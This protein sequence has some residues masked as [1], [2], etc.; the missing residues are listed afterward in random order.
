M[1]HRASARE[2]ESR[3]REEAAALKH[4]CVTVLRG[5]RLLVLLLL[6]F[7][8]AYAHYAFEVGRALF[9][10]FF[11]LFHGFEAPDNGVS[12][13]RENTRRCSG[14]FSCRCYRAD[15]CF[16]LQDDLRGSLGEE[17]L[18]YGALDEESVLDEDGDL[19]VRHDE[20][21]EELLA[22]APKPRVTQK[23]TLAPPKTKSPARSKKTGGKALAGDD[24]VAEISV[25]D[26]PGRV[27]LQ[28]LSTQDWHSA[29]EN[30]GSVGGAAVL[31]SYWNVDEGHYP[32]GHTLRFTSG[33]AY[34]A[35]PPLVSV[36][37][38]T[39]AVYTER[40]LKITADTFG[41]HNFDK[42]FEHVAEMAKV[43]AT[44]DRKVPGKPFRVVI[45]N[46][47]GRER[48]LPETREFIIV[49]GGGVKIGIVGII[50]PEAYKD[51]QPK[52]WGS[53]KILDPVKSAMAVQKKARAAGAEM[54]VCL[55]HMGMKSDAPKTG[56]LIDFARNVSG[57]A[58]I[59]GDHTGVQMSNL[60]VNGQIVLETLRNGGSYARTRIVWDTAAKKVVQKEVQFVVPTITGVVPDSKML[61]MLDG[62]R[63]KLRPIY[64]RVL[65][66]SPMFFSRKDGNCNVGSAC[67]MSQGNLIA[68]SMR[69]AY[70]VQ[71]A[72]TNTGG[73]RSGFACNEAGG[74][75]FCPANQTNKAP[76]AITVGT[77]RGVL[78]FANTVITAK[79]SGPTLRQLLEAMV[80]GDFPQV[81]GICFTYSG[82]KVVSAF[83][84]ESDGSC[85]KRPV[86]LSTTTNVYTIA[87]TEY[88]ATRD[89]FPD[90]RKSSDYKTQK[91]LRDG[92]EQ[93]ISR[94]GFQMPV[95]QGRI[96]CT[97][98]DKCAKPTN[99]T[100]W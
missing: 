6:G 72:V 100:A 97:G 91:E 44:K 89:G 56:E 94:P 76:F 25:K 4:I 37:N 5:M 88:L 55:V 82:A 20:E 16:F 69:A 18:D 71:F 86:D 11:R 51:Q 95:I 63:D 78:P 81:S 62:F 40:L 49:R 42:G 77:C 19:D 24:A 96:V 70:P 92:V 22:L 90:L 30:V 43:A 48:F 21:R 17:A 47:A 32:A 85:S 64:Q 1:L 93:F 58:V 2:R 54:V 38:E 73:I 87:T 60:D 66:Y 75:G 23:A 61:L 36:F 8:A 53:L 45:S 14:C 13:T 12:A 7:S 79:I 74:A 80:T 27:R 41:N 65:G 59:F 28:F 83:F 10:F 98:S 57:F 35:T 3:L 99:P 68:D 26:A 34:G 15:F 84:A 67:E 31:S 46:M 9:F 52:N 29:I 33:D 39:P 50:S